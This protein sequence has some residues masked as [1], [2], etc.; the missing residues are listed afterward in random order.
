MSLKK[1]IGTTLVTGLAASMLV[2]GISLAPGV[3]AP[4]E[5]YTCCYKIPNG[6]WGGYIRST[7]VYLYRYDYDTVV[8]RK[9]DIYWRMVDGRWQERV[10][11]VTLYAV[12]SI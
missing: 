7:D 4:A 2:T 10:Q 6:T 11:Y 8:R 3:A 5:A 12:H 9:T 1:K